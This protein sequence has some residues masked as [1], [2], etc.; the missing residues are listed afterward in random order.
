[1]VI[2]K[3]WPESQSELPDVKPYFPY[4]Y[5]LYFIKGIIAVDGLIVVPNVLRCKF[6]KKIHESHLGI[7]KSKLL[8]KTLVYWPGYNNEVKTIC[9]Q[10]KQCRE[11]QIMPQNVPNLQVQASKPGE[12][13]GWDIVYIKVN[14]HLVVVDYKSVCIFERKLPNVTSTSITEALKSI[15]CD[16]RAPD[17]LISDNMRYFVLNEFE[18]FTAKWNIVHVTSS[19]RYPQGNSHIGKAIQSINAIYKKYHNIKMGLL[20]LETTPIVSG[21]DQK[22]PAGTFFRCQLKANVPI[23]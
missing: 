21:H 17:K 2:Q 20:M 5:T 1:M 10:C 4:R 16:I 12:I 8:A 13:Y 18:E 9:K 6:L 14:Q 19:P 23:F 3:S 15:F 11:N 7:V 22:A